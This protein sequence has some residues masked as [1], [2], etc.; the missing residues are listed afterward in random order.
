MLPREY[1]EYR[2]S[3]AACRRRRPAPAPGRETGARVGRARA[4]LRTHGE[5]GCAPPPSPCSAGLSSDAL[6]SPTTDSSTSPCLLASACAAPRAVSKEVA[7]QC[8]GRLWHGTPA[9]PRGASGGR[10]VGRPE[11][12]HPP[13]QIRYT[14]KFCVPAWRAD[15]RLVILALARSSR[16]TP[17]CWSRCGRCG[18]GEAVAAAG[19]PARRREAC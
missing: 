4:G 10:E 14:R 11:P 15:L 3:A 12:R 6:S 9:A 18:E 2:A 7:V 13:S 5:S 19:A 17:P 16:A 8:A 1:G